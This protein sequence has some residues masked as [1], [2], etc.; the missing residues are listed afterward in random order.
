[1]E[2]VACDG[3]R[4]R[5]GSAPAGDVWLAGHKG[6]W[7]GLGLVDS[8]VCPFSGLFDLLGS[9]IFFYKIRCLV[10]IVYISSS[11]KTL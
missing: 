1:M 7:P 2:Y 3:D 6:K 9:R 5:K 8:Q 4:E 11:P 10:Y